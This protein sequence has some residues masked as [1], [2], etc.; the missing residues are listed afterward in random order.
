VSTPPPTW[1]RTWWIMAGV[2]LITVSA[3]VAWTEQHRLRV[4]AQPPERVPVLVADFGNHTGDQALDDSLHFVLERELSASDVIT[5]VQRPRVQDVLPLMRRSADTRL[6]PDIARE[7]A[8]R[9]G[10]VRALVTGRVDSDGPGYLL[11]VD[12]IDVRSGATVASRSTGVGTRSKLLTGVRQLAGWARHA[13]GETPRT[14]LSDSRPPQVTTASLSALNLYAQAMDALFHDRQQVARALLESALREDPSFA[15]AH[16][17]LT[18]VLQNGPDFR[19]VAPLAREHDERAL[20][21]SRDTSPRERLHVEGTY[22]MNRGQTDKAVAA[23]EALIKID[24]DDAVAH[25]QLSVLYFGQRRIPD[26]LRELERMVALQPNDFTFL[27]F[28]AQSYALWAAD[29][30]HARPLVQRAAALWP[31]QR[32]AL[33]SELWRLTLPPESARRAAWVLM[34]PAYERWHAGDVGGA[35]QE[36]QRV[37]DTDPLPTPRDRD[38]LLTIASALKMSA[39]QLRGGPRSWP[40]E[41]GTQIGVCE[42]NLAVLADIVDDIPNLRRHMLRVP[43]EREQRALRFVRAGLYAQAEY[44]MSH[45]QPD[46]PFYW[47]ARGELA[48]R[49]GHLAEA[50]DDLHRGIEAEHDTLSERYLGAESL[51]DALMQLKRPEEALKVLQEAA[52][53]EPKYTRTGPSAAFWLRVLDRLSRMYRDLGRTAE[54]DA[55]DARLRRLLEFADPDHPIV[56]R[57][58]KMSHGVWSPRAAA[59]LTA[60][61]Q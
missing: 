7:V 16:S 14:A 9:D 50:V 38:A 2:L 12:V 20:A 45:N 37:L 10:D 28:T 43:V 39:G 60:S 52:A 40:C 51:A 5:I 55:V 8:L 4:S 58:A 24:P 59:R 56:T 42:L 25:S 21:L 47:T 6:T 61:G 32:D 30:D 17:W 35:L 19:S 34:F 13:L 31:A 26:A 27:A 46:G 11:T 18:V 1:A 23:W 22:Y 49:R 29:L 44:V 53:A 33:G 48:R 57:L 54:A 36:M 3:G 15:L 41:G